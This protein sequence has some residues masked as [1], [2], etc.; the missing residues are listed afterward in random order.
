MKT[1]FNTFLAACLCLCFNFAAAQDDQPTI[2][3]S[4]DYMQV[5]PGNHKDYLACEK[6][7]K[8]IHQHQKDAGIIEGWAIE[9]VLSPGGTDADYNYIT[10]QRFKGEKQLSAYLA[11]PYMPDNWESLLTADEVALVKRTSELR[12]WVKNEVWS[13]VERVLADDIE[14]AKV[15]VFNYFGIPEG[16]RRSEHFKMERDIW[17]PIHTARVK[18]GQ[19]KGWVMLN[20]ELPMGSMYDYG[21]ATVDIFKDMDQFW[22][23]FPED[24]FEKIHAGKDMDD[25]WEQT[26]AVSNRLSA[27]LR[28]ALDST[29]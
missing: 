27:E 17:M 29:N 12:T 5:E 18:D 8:K 24:Y 26:L 25:L 15:V 21:V 14:D 7:W 28:L 1:V 10:R 11:Q 4:M 2:Y 6:A 9:M 3:Y 23:P 13:S 22:A 20:R 16:K 19:M